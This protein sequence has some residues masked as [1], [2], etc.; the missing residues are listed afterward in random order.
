MNDHK[1]Q[2]LA[3]ILKGWVERQLLRLIGVRVEEGIY[4]IASGKV[5]W[6]PGER[7]PPLPRRG[8]YIYMLVRIYC[9][10][11]YRPVSAG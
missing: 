1:R 10:R 2:V 8:L 3:Q 11:I 5:V 4:T 7:G 9:Q 6:Y